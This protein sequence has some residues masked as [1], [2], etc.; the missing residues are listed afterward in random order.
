MKKT[1]A[2]KIFTNKSEEKINTES[3]IAELE[4]VKK[5]RIEQENE[6]GDIGFK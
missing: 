1:T 2:Y 4:K 6:K 3:L 5:E